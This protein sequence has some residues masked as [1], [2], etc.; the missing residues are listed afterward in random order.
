[1]GSSHSLQIPNRC[2]VEHPDIQQ[3]NGM[4]NPE[5]ETYMGKYGGERS[6]V[7]STWKLQ[8]FKSE[9]IRQSF[10]SPS[11]FAKVYKERPCR[12]WQELT[13]E[14]A[15]SFNTVQCVQYALHH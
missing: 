7:K 3:H 10:F 15:C 4:A 14:I 1:M 12:S 11:E 6:L 5:T 9:V 2:K 8:P 13:K